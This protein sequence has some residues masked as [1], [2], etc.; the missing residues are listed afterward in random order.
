MDMKLSLTS[1]IVF[2][3]FAFSFPTYSQISWQKMPGPN[4]YVRSVVATANNDLYAG[5]ATYGVFKS[6]DAGLTWQNISVALGDSLIK[7]LEVS[8]NNE[9][10]AATTQHG[11][12]KYNGASW[13][14][15]NNGLPASIPS[16]NSFAKDNAGNIYAAASNG[17][18][19]KW[20]GT[21]WTNINFN[22][23]APSLRAVA[24]GPT[25]TLYAAN[26]GTG[27]YKFNGTNSWSLFGTGLPNTNMYKLAVSSTDTLFAVAGNTVC[28]IPASGGTWTQVTNGLP[29]VAIT[30][31]GIDPQNRLFVG[32]YN[33]NVEGQVYRSTNNGNSWSFVSASL[34][35]HVF[36]SFC[37]TSSNNVF[38]SGSGVYKSN[39]NGSS[40]T[41]INA[42]LDARKAILCFAGQ[43]DGTLFVG[44]TSQGV[45]RSTDNGAT[46]QQKN[47]GI[48]YSNSYL[49][50]PLDNG[51]LLY[52]SYT[53]LSSPAYLYRSTNNGDSWTQ[54]S[55]NGTDLY[56]TL[57]Q[58]NADTVWAG[59]RFG[60]SRL[61]YSINHGATWTN[62]SQY[63]S[64]IWD[65]ELTQG[66][67][68]FTGS[69]T[70]GVSRSLNGG[71]TWT[72]GIGNTIPWYGNLL[73]VEVD[74]NG[75]V[76]A[77]TDWWQN[78]LW[79][80]IP[81]SN[82]ESWTKFLDSDLSLVTTIYKLIFDD[83]NNA[84]L[85]TGNG[86]NNQPIYRA[87]NSVWNENT[88]WYSVSDG[89]PAIAPVRDLG[90]DAAGYM[91]A[92]CYT[93]NGHNAGLYRS[94]VP[95]NCNV[96]PVISGLND[97]CGSEVVSYSVPNVAGTTY[98]WSTSANGTI[99]SGQSTNQISVQWNSGTIGTVSLTQTQ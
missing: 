7:L 15:V 74:A 22:L 56:T 17:I 73:E 35:T 65:L 2:F 1:A 10:F 26:F 43:P 32:N 30:A 77:G 21:I 96:N 64:A 58:H 83:Q 42:G 75:Y 33:S 88:N 94:A 25:G 47:V 24:V 90:F 93:S 67:T 55:S 46:W 69:E 14:A 95:V 13:V 85:T 57:Q 87:D 92:V 82:G 81:A 78:I 34:T 63:F 37:F 86:A 16:V 71:T 98:I 4:E 62:L 12:Y 29:D 80:S 91:Y 20:N 39:N 3:L 9:V 6:T 27:V 61:S 51:D 70:E 89:L 18:V 38:V 66:S 31:I 72:Q 59:G 28:R 41:D 19:Y 79:F 48:I 68:M 60:G 45:W 52:S 8:S 49:I 54:V 40:W 11:I 44:T 53:G 36:W 84:Y 50:K 97:V 23:S 5:T 99:L 76:F